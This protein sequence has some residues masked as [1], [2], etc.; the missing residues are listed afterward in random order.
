LEYAG[1]DSGLSQLGRAIG[2]PPIEL[3]GVSIRIYYKLF[4][5]ETDLYGQD[6]DLVLG[7]ESRLEVGCDVSDDP[8]LCHAAIFLRNTDYSADSM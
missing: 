4:V 7:D 2:H 8:Y 5:A 3:S 1:S 6:G